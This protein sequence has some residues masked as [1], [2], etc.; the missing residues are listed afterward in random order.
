MRN[1]DIAEAM[2]SMEASFKQHVDGHQG[3]F[4]VKA[5]HG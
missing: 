1:E 5:I 3:Y 4:I 2:R